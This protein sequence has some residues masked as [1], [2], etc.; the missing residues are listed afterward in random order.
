MEH[1]VNKRTKKEKNAERKILKTKLQ[2]LYVQVI[3]LAINWTLKSC[4]EK[5]LDSER[6]NL[7]NIKVFQNIVRG[8]RKNRNK[9]PR[10]NVKNIFLI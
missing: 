6:A 3:P 8:I 4:N 9:S 7:D 5:I 2:K 1:E 10:K